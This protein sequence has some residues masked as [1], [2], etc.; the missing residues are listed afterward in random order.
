LRA[1]LAQLGGLDPTFEQLTNGLPYLDA[2][3]CES[4]RMHPITSSSTRQV[5]FRALPTFNELRRNS[6][7]LGSRRRYYSLGQANRRC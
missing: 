5:N 1:E 2:V 4:L 3:V 6:F 7:C